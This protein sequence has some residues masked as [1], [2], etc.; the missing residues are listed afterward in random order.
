[1]RLLQSGILFFFINLTCH[2]VSAKDYYVAV[3]GDDS[4]SGSIESPLQTIGK[5]AKLVKAGDHV[6]VRAGTYRNIDFNDGDIWEG[7][8]AVIINSNGTADQYITF[9][10]YQNEKVII[11]FDDNY[12]VLIRNASYIIFRGFEIKGMNDLITYEEAIQWWGIYKDTNNVI[13]DL[14]VELGIDPSDKSLLGSDIPKPDLI[15]VKRPN[16]FTGKGL[17]AFESHHIIMENNIVH[18]TPGSGI[19]VQR[20][21]YCTVRNNEV[22][23]CTFYTPAGVGAI[24]V[25]ESQTM[26][27]DES[28]DLKIQIINNSV[29]DNQNKL[30]S[31]HPNKTFISFVIDEGSGIFLTRN[32][33]TEPDV[34]NYDFG[35]ILIAN[36]LSYRNG[37]SGIVCHFTNNVIIEQNTVYENGQ[38]NTGNPGGIGINNSDNVTVRNN[39]AFA[40]PNKF[41]LG[42]VGGVITNITIENN[43]VFNKNGTEETTKN[44]GTEGWIDTNPFLIAPWQDNFRPSSFSPAV[45]AGSTAINQ[46]IDFY[47]NA[48]QDTMP[49]IGAIEFKELLKLHY[50]KTGEMDEVLF[51][52]EEN[53]NISQRAYPI[54]FVAK[55]IGTAPIG[56]IVMEYINPDID[57]ILYTSNSEL[58][59]LFGHNQNDL[60]GSIL[61]TNSRNQKLFCYIYSG[62]DGTGEILYKSKNVFKIVE[63][64]LAISSI[65]PEKT[66]FCT[67]TNFNL[68]LGV[69]GTFNSNNTF[70][71]WLSDKNG[72]FYNGMKIGELASDLGGTIN[73]TLPSNLESGLQ[74]KLKVYSTKEAVESA[75]V[76]LIIQ[77]PATA[78][79]S[80]PEYLL[81]GNQE[82]LA[83]AHINAS[84]TIKPAAKADFQAGNSIS[85]LPGFEASSGAVFCASIKPV[86]P[87]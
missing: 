17:V 18:D 48:R 77:P 12:G 27:G 7:T 63:S 43:I 68:E 54:T 47:R 86:C 5:A 10:P 65:I 16:N 70:I 29:H 24:T 53:M 35:S 34:Y 79:I 21:D 72:N 20:S 56:S 50:V 19:R 74:Y 2:L 15:S 67:T 59:S 49:D 23:N 62:P 33:S 30:V 52:L 26:P 32:S 75:N 31:W 64:D 25:A 46:T 80:N 13:H 37:A 85:L 40:L 36:N 3:T 71:A 58:Y 61:D 66:T 6:Y 87:E 42:K 55:P 51:P 39:I 38:N 41:A 76:N 73:C 14:A 84:N 8:N 78:N 1:M 28:M 69:N 4:D 83:T 11:E 44:I 81:S 60:I 9:E 57:T 45:N 82:I 22:Y